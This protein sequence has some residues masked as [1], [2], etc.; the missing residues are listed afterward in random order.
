MKRH[1]KD[2]LNFINNSE[3]LNINIIKKKNREEK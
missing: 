2:K 3:K 1:F